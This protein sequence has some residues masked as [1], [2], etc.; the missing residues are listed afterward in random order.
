MTGKDPDNFKQCELSTL[1]NRSIQENPDDRFTDIGAFEF[2]YESLKR[3]IL[4]KSMA[5]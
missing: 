1:I 5:F 2:H 3:I 4:N